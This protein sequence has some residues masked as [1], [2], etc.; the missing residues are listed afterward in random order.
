MPDRARPASHPATP[1]IETAGGANEVRDGHEEEWSCVGR[2]VFVAER[3]PVEIAVEIIC[4]QREL[5]H[6]LAVG[7]L[8]S[9]DKFQGLLCESF[10]SVAVDGVEGPQGV[11]AEVPAEAGTGGVERWVPACHQSGFVACAD[12][13]LI[14]GN[15]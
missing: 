3:G 8:A 1:K 6:D 9:G 14:D 2:G 13:R 15:L 5:V 12:L 4:G 10:V 11:A 7:A